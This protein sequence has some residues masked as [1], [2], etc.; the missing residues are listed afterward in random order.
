[1]IITSESLRD[2][3][4]TDPNFNDLVTWKQ[5]KGIS[6]TLVTVE[7]INDD[8]DYHYDGTYGDGSETFD[9]LAARIRNFI[10]DAYL[11]WET[12]YILLGGDGD[13]GG[14]GEEIVPTRCLYA[15]YVSQPGDEKANIIPA[16]LY[17]AGLDGSWN[18]NEDEYWGDYWA[19]YGEID[20]LPEVHIGRAPVGSTGQMANF[21]RKTI[22]YEASTLGVTPPAYLKKSLMVGEDLDTGPGTNWGG[23]LKD[24]VLGCFPAKFQDQAD[25][26]YDRDI[27]PSHYW[28]WE[29][30]VERIEEGQ[31]IINHI[32]HAWWG[33][34]MR[35]TQS[36]IRALNNNP[37]WCLVYSQG[38]NAGA[39]DNWDP[40]NDEYRDSGDAVGEEFVAADGGAFAFVGNSRYGLA[41]YGS[42]Y[43]EK[44]FDAVFYQN[45]AHL[46]MALQASKE[47]NVSQFSTVEMRGLYYALNLLGDPETVLWTDPSLCFRNS[48]GE[49]VVRF[50]QQGN[51]YVSG[52]LYQYSS[53]QPMDYPVP[54][55]EVVIKNSVGFVLMVIDL[56]SGDLYI[57]ASLAEN[58]DDLN[59]DSG[60]DDYVIKN[61]I[62]EVVAY[63]DERGY[64]WLKGEVN[65]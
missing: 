31:H 39:F 32:G 9:D 5:S 3:W 63:F 13:G 43:D 49:D 46:G 38:C 41:V 2:A 8:S 20:P 10:K 33:E 52:T 4:Y 53:H 7:D 16:D 54:H 48:S 35:M 11:N 45:K 62:G 51:L 40:Y 21:V 57:Y 65:P 36:K 24:D 28:S 61:G 42:A 14:V 44:F 17:Y 30:I 1:V 34:V 64:L 58:C 25:T 50:D 26:L 55:N 47:A 22:E 27:Y 12:E 59:P 18:S 19:P 23:D 37:D 6:A 29:D 56:D 15:P 60:D